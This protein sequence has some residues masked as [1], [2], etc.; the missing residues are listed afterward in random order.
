MEGIRTF[1]G[2]RTKEITVTS[3]MERESALVELGN[4]TNKMKFRVSRR[5]SCYG[6]SK[7]D[8]E[9]L[10]RAISSN[11]KRGRQVVGEE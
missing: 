9:D 5:L 10:T 6:V 2:P 3:S 8:T 7:V 4:K 11:R 1:T